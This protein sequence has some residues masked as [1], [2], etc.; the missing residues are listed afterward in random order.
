[1]S[2]LLNPYRFGSSGGGGGFTPA[3]LTGLVGWWD[4]SDLS[5]FANDDRVTQ[6]D[7]K[8]GN[9]YHMTARN[10]GCRYVSDDGSGRSAVRTSGSTNDIMA[11][12]VGPTTRRSQPYTRFV[13][14]ALLDSGSDPISGDDPIT[15]LIR[16]GSGYYNGTFLSATFTA[17]PAIYVGL[18][19]G[20]SSYIRVDG[21]QLASGNTG[22]NQVRRL[23]W[24]G[25]GLDGSP[26]AAA[27]R[28]YEDGFVDGELSASDLDNLE[29]YLSTKWSI[30][31]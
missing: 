25:R 6:V 10:L 12:N 8:S 11:A 5:G 4:T 21:T 7:D 27:V 26:N 18:G 16:R 20:A 14:C 3:D 1:M 17:D 31:I 23:A 28:V 24:G 29:S 15:N 2:L 13:V 30:T 19:N 22:A 9:G